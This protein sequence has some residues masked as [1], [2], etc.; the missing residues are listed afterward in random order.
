LAGKPVGFE[1]NMT[2]GGAGVTPKEKCSLD[3][4]GSFPERC[5]GR[6]AWGKKGGKNNVN[7]VERRSPIMF[8]GAKGGFF[9]R[10]GKREGQLKG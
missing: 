5:C 6:D 2:W 10:R 9:G 7:G 3:Q 8:E 1:Q 4:V